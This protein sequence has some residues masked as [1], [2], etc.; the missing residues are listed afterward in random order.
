MKINILEPRVFNRISA[1]EVVERPASI[2]KELVENSIDAGATNIS[3]EIESGGIKKI[4]VSDDGCGIEKDDLIVAFKP[5]ATSKI[6]EVE[7]L[8]SIM[9]LGFRGEAL[10]S[11]SSVCHI[12]LSSKVPDNDVGYSINVDGGIFSEIKEVA[13]QNGTTL[14]A[15]DLFFN[16]P[17]RLKFLKKPKIEEGEVTHL[18]EKFMLSHPEIAFQYYIDGKQIYNTRCSSMQD[19]IYTIYGREV[20]DSLIEVDYSERNYRIQGYITKPKISKSNRTFQ[21]LFINNRYVENYLISSAVQG[22]YEGFLM[23]GRFPV[24]VLNLSVP[25]DSVDVNVHPS[26]KEVKFENSTWIFGFITRALDKA[27][28]SVGQIATFGIDEKYEEQQTLSFI[29]D[30]YNPYYKDKKEPLSE[31]EG[32]RYIVTVNHTDEFK[33]LEEVVIKPEEKIEYVDKRQ[34]I[35]PPDFSEVKLEVEK[36]PK[37]IEGGD[38]YFDMPDSPHA[39]DILHNRTKSEEEVLKEE[40]IEKEKFL[41]SSV[42]EEM[43]ILGTI[44]NTY[45]VV[46][47][48]QALYFLDQHAAH[49]RL[50]FDKLENQINSQALAI[51][52]LFLPYVFKVGSLEASRLENVFQELKKIGFTITCKDKNTYQIENIPLVLANLSLKKFIDEITRDSILFEKKPSDFIHEKL[53]QT[54]CK[55]AIKGGDSISKD[56]CAYLIEEVRKGKMLCPHGR[57]VCLQ[58]TKKEIEKMFG[59]IV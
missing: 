28:S 57:P 49:E 47:L 44:F 24:Y 35:L 4:Q 48:R 15:R 55:H 30:N 20:Y 52:P 25:T 58:F 22:V 8:E 40:Q 36:I 12:Y 16:T 11:I 56:Q 41:E 45:I 23:K 3:I 26:K 51:Q 29:D 37:N 32:S 13:R 18:V 39:F 2:V 59:R 27:L 5:H 6:K 34:P 1:G 19:I 38:L 33:P 9:S 46:E 43:K 17:A 10:A 42:E 7:D 14:I 50:L 21:T 53:C 54:A 31:T